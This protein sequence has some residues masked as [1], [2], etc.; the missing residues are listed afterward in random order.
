M[1]R[2]NPIRI[3]LV[4]SLAC[5]LPAS[6][7]SSIPSGYATWATGRHFERDA[8][9]PQSG[10][11]LRQV[12]DALRQLE[13]AKKRESQAGTAKEI[14]EAKR[15]REEAEKHLKLVCSTAKDQLER[16]KQ[17]LKRM[18]DAIAM[19]QKELEEWTAQ[20]QEAQW[21]AFFKAIDLLTAGMLAFAAESDNVANGLKGAIKKY[22]AKL[23]Q[24]GKALDPLQYAKLE[25]LNRRKLT[26]EAAASTAKALQSGKRKIGVAWDVFTAQTR[27]I[28]REAAS[29]Q[30]ELMQIASDPLF[31]DLLEKEGLM[32]LVGK[33]RS[34]T[35]FPKKPYLVNFGDFLVDYG[36]DAT[37]WWESRKRILQQ[38]NLTDTQLRAVDSLKKQ[39]ERTT[40]A[41]NHCP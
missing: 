40:A 5:S 8:P 19:G 33:L 11:L 2:G 9:G 35:L 37:K 20:N 41:V 7:L 6:D 17:A 10:S 38:Y 24:Q 3:A 22:E 16:D 25:S 26:I 34:R 18:L 39:I 13:Q 31:K 32:A 4:V 28:D 14:E 1:L 21:H 15:A 36:Y 30:D 12:E 27:T 29:L 23:K